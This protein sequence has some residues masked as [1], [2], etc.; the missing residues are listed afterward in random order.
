MIELLYGRLWYKHIRNES[1]QY[2]VTLLMESL[3]LSGELAEERGRY[4][5]QGKAITTLVEYEKEQRHARQ[6][7]KNSAKYGP[8]DADY[9][10]RD[11]IDYPGITRAG[12]RYR[13][14]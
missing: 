9:Y 12:W 2:K 8:P 1:F 4:I 5:V 13:F 3:A 11:G 7:E 14:T 6:Q 10:R